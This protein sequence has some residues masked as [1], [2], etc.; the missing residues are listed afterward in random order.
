MS[1]LVLGGTAD[2]APR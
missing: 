1:K 2:R